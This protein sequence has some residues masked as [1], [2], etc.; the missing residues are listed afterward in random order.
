MEIR[1]G[2]FDRDRNGDGTIQKDELVKCANVFKAKDNE[3]LKSVGILADR[4]NSLA[5]YWIY[6]LKEGYTNP[7]DGELLY[8]AVGENGIKAKYA[9]YNVQ[10]LETPIALLKDQLFSI[11]A[12]VFG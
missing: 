8:S 12:R 11:V 3:M 6:L 7:E 5:E 4:P 2:V 10:D 9:G 1:E